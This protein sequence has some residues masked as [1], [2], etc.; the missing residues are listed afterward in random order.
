M[1]KS[2]IATATTSARSRPPPITCFHLIERAPDVA[3]EE[4]A[5]SNVI[6]A[7]A[8]CAAQNRARIRAHPAANW[9]NTFIWGVSPVRLAFFMMDSF[10]LT[11]RD[12]LKKREQE[13]AIKRRSE[14][15]AGIL[16]RT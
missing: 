5:L 2:S 9:R 6:A 14:Q 10:S 8:G 15:S 11:R 1:K 3:A 12:S 7:D 13:S 4:L 16:A